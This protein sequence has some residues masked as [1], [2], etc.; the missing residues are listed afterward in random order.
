MVPLQVALL[1]TGLAPDMT[2]PSDECRLIGNCMEVVNKRFF[3]EELMAS[4]LGSMRLLVEWASHRSP[5]WLSFSFHSYRTIIC[6]SMEAFFGLGDFILD[7]VAFNVALQKPNK[8]MFIT[9]VPV[10]HFR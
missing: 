5:G 10:N 4:A 9:Q 8:K 6:E 3:V 1:T 7:F 2:E